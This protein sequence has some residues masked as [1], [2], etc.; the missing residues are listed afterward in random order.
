MSTVARVVNGQ[1]IIR[2]SYDKIFAPSVVELGVKHNSYYEEQAEEEGVTPDFYLNNPLLS[3]EVEGEGS[4]R[5]FWTRS[6]FLDKNR[7]IFVGDAGSILYSEQFYSRYILPTYNFI[8][9][10]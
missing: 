7:Y 1:A 4:P 5:I 10:Y 9:K 3:R 8:G 6:L 2:T